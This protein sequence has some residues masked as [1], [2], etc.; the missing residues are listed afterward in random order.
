MAQRTLEDTIQNAGNP[1]TMVRNSQI[2]AYIYPVVAPEFSNW[3]DE[4]RAWRTSCVLY[5]QSHHMV[6]LHL[7]GP[8]AL[9]LL[10]YLGPNTFTNFAV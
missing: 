10:T 1:A 9:K 2:G 7:E 5:D 6:N 3:R 8:D 4:Q